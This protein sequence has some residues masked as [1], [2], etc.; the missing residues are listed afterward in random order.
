MRYI[1]NDPATGFDD[2]LAFGGAGV[3]ASMGQNPATHGGEPFGQLYLAMGDFGSDQGWSVSQ[4]PRIVG[5]V[6]GDGIPDIVGFG[7]NSTFAAIGSRDAAGNLHFAL[8]PTRTIGDF[9][10][11]EGWSGSDPRTIRALSD[12]AG[13]GHA[14]LILSGAFNT[15]V[16]RFD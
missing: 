16:W 10:T 11:A 15:Q 4:T 14:D 7:F 13:S 8:D 9:G 12:V 3:R 5:D 2:I 6:N 1:V